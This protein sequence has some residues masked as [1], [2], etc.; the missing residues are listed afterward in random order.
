MVKYFILLFIV[1]SFMATFVV[2]II[3][4]PDYLYRHTIEGNF[5]TNWYSIDNFSPN[6]LRPSRYPFS[7]GEQYSAENLWREFHIKDA[8]I[9]MPYRHPQLK[10]VP[11]LKRTDKKEDFEMGFEFLGSQNKLVSEI[12]FLPNIIFSYRPKG[13]KLFELPI[14]QAIVAQNL[15]ATIW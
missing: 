9:P 8:I 10:V 2:G 3:I 14:G 6:L 13:Q 5:P 4:A 1:L 11:I 7:F 15:P 12:H